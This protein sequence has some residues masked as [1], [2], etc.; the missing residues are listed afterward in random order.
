MAETEMHPVMQVNRTIV[1]REP[2]YELILSRANFNHLCA[3]CPDFDSLIGFSPG[4]AYFRIFPDPHG[5]MPESFRPM[6][7]RGGYYAY[8]GAPVPMIPPDVTAEELDRLSEQAYD[9]LE[10]AMN[11]SGRIPI[12]EE[13]SIGK[14]TLG[15]VIMK[16]EREDKK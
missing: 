9:N 2:Q 15:H 3:G 8:V 11:E 6:P 7:D 5:A 13:T 4:G 10:K 1:D 16:V 12:E 14:I